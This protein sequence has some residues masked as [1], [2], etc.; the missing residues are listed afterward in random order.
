MFILISHSNLTYYIWKL[1]K[2][3]INFTQMHKKL[4]LTLILLVFCMNISNSQTI[5]QP[6]DPN[7]IKSIHRLREILDSLGNSTVAIQREK[8][9]NEFWDILILKQRIPFVLND[10]VLFLYKGN[11]HNVAWAGDFNG[12]NPGDSGY[13]GRQ[14]GKSDIWYMENKFPADAR[15]DYKIVADKEWILDSS[16]PNIQF[17][18]FG[19]NSELRMPKWKYPMETIPSKDIKHGSLSE[20]IKFRSKKENLNYDVQYK[21]YLPYSYDKS[22]NLPVIYVTDGE[23][24]SESRQGSMIEILDNLIFKSKIKPLIAVFIDPRN[25]DTLSENRRMQEYR[26]SKAFIDFVCNELLPHI[27]S[28]YH[29]IPDANDRLIMGASLGGWNAAWFGLKRTDCFHLIGI[30][31]PAFPDEI[32]NAY[33]DSPLLPLKIFMSTGTIHDTQI[34]AR[35]M[36]TVLEKKKYLLK[37]IEVNEG[38]SWGN[39]RALVDDVLIYFFNSS[40]KNFVH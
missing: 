20:N 38:H 7:Q 34:Q 14:A 6:L 9:V 32:I 29:T 16:N 17:S 5:A 2:H 1:L 31:S 27:D 15:L 37:Y 19:P 10:S 25:P 11:V 18:G 3:R 26:E 13:F 39:W 33:A 30:Q 24:Y 8:Q 4:Y 28:N 40:G 36:K 12:W 23:E 35:N 21:V 22:E